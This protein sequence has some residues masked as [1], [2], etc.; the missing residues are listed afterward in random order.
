MVGLFGGWLSVFNFANFLMCQPP[1]I[2][3]Y[4]SA[5]GS[6]Y[7]DIVREGGGDGGR[8]DGGRGDGGRSAASATGRVPCCEP[9]HNLPMLLFVFVFRLR[10]AF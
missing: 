5:L 1:P 8:G 4:N 6:A 7:A 2:T 9:F 3:C 10:D